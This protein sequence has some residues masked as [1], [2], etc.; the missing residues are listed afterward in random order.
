MGIRARTIL[1]SSLV[2]IGLWAGLL[3]AIGLN[4]RAVSTEIE[5]REID[6][7]LKQLQ[8]VI[9]ADEDHLDSIIGDWAVW[10]DTYRFVQ[11]RNQ[12]YVDNNLQDDSLRTLDVDFMVFVD[13]NGR[14]AFAKSID[15]DTRRD[16]ALPAGLAEYIGTRPSITRLTDPRTPVSGWLSLPKGTVLLSARPIVTSDLLSPI[17]GTLVTGYVVNTRRVGGIAQLMP[18]KT[19]AAW[20]PEQSGTPP[21]AVAARDALLAAPGAMYSRADDTVRG[22]SLVMGIDS[23]PAMLFQV[24]EE[25]TAVDLARRNLAWS[26]GLTALLGAVLLL[27]LGVTLDR[28]VLR[29][30]SR[31]SASLVDVSRAGA[32]ARV[33]VEGSDEIAR[34]ATD[35]NEMLADLEE[36]HSELTY[37]ATH[38][39]L[40]RLYN[41]RRFE[42]ELA[43]ELAEHHRLQRRGAM[44]WLD[45]DHFKEVN[46]TLGHAA[47]DA[48][49][50]E[51]GD[52]LREET[53]GYCVLARLGGDE[54][55]MLI[56]EADETEAVSAANRLLS[57]LGDHVFD[58]AGHPV[59]VSGSVGVVLY[60]EHGD[61]A[62][63]LLA[64]ADLAMYYAKGSG[65]NRVAVYSPHDGR[66]SEMAARLGS[67]EAIVEGL[68][69]GGFELY[70]EPTRNV[71][72][73]SAGPY[74]LLLR[75]HA[76]DGEIILPGD[77]IPTAERLGLIRDIDR[78]VIQEAIRLL[79]AEQAMGRDTSF[80]VNMSGCAFSDPDLLSIIRDAFAATDAYPGR[81]VI[82]ITE[83]AAIGDILG[84]QA[85]IV[86]L[87]E[88]GCRFSLDDF[89]SGAS[90]FF[91]LKHLPIDFLKIDGSLI[92]S[93]RDDS[94][95]AHF[96]RAIVEMC[97]GLGIATV[98]KYVEDETLVDVIARHRV[99]YA[100]GH[101][102]GYPLPV[103]AYLK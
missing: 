45:L 21:E 38:D 28:T 52:V 23:K 49:L 5:R 46:D 58:V 100:Q 92:R 10:D 39:G 103:S 102:I 64:R 72:D 93:L 30:L 98:A 60:P 4:S 90:S 6:Q 34:V 66:S 101:W 48:L 69:D 94:V 16:S 31:L 89:G 22:Y 56:P 3:F 57:V 75:L 59:R 35:I 80:S 77:I 19:V 81:L 15:P 12:A 44:L 85:F 51:L 24:T 63:E 8:A 13:L 78:W 11:D 53:R 26:T 55:G 86:A 32:S 74:E 96:V 99:D 73:G 36:S 65:R 70:A 97:S 91:Y 9:A 20:G 43:R 71:R 2:V 25:R 88:I 76:A 67:A 61:E 79:A 17:A 68:R 50:I 37:L 18:S 41:R 87:K 42:T 95:D 47:G 83:T 54:F 27:G 62:D 40:T 33:A 84:A 7:T 14:I 1:L 82:E 29:R